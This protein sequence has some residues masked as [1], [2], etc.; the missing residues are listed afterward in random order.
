[1]CLEIGPIA[2]RLSL[3]VLKSLLFEWQQASYKQSLKN[4]SEHMSVASEKNNALTL[5]ALPRLNG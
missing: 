1:M 2:H 5:R 3:Q 4:L